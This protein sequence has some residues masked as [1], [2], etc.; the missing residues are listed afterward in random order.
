MSTASQPAA[1]VT[2]SA[3]SRRLRNAGQGENLLHV[4][5]TLESRAMVLEAELKEIDDDINLNA[6][7]ARKYGDDFFADGAARLSQSRARS[8]GMAAFC[9]CGERCRCRHV[10][11]LRVDGKAAAPLGD[12]SAAAGR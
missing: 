3:L 10:C 7:M 9:A 1:H 6:T 5:N 12:S 11:V 2:Y 4:L 8:H